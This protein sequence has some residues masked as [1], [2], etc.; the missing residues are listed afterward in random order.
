[1]GMEIE[2][3]NT[4]PDERNTNSPPNSTN[5]EVFA[6]TLTLSQALLK[7]S[8]RNQQASESNHRVIQSLLDTLNKTNNAL[9]A[10]WETQIETQNKAFALQMQTITKAAQSVS[11]YAS[12]GAKNGVN[13]A[14][15]EIREEALDAFGQA[16]KPDLSD[17]NQVVQEIREAR[18]G[19]E[20]AARYLT[21]KAVGL[22]V[23]IAVLPLLV[24]LG[25]DWHLVQKIESEQTTINSLDRIQVQQQQ[26]VKQQQSRPSM[27]KPKPKPQAEATVPEEQP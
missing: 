16:L 5:D 22:Y 7:A 6:S 26:S 9:S 3:M 13:Q 15:A 12:G 20:R 8:E 19:F 11:A 2:R 23:L 24:L 21:W 1:M 27:A 14:I 4:G 10:K 18:E 17:L 25:W